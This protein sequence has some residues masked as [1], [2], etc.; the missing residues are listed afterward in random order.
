GIITLDLWEGKKGTIGKQPTALAI[1]HDKGSQPTHI[2]VQVD[3][4]RL[5][6]NGTKASASDVHELAPML[7]K[8]WKADAFGLGVK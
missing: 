3:G 6:V 5:Q 7:L 2:T 1:Q 8:L 4:G